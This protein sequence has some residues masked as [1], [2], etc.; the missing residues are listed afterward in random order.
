[1]LSAV[2]VFVG[3]SVLRVWK[4][5]FEVEMCVC[6]HSGQCVIK[7]FHQKWVE[8]PSSLSS[9]KSCAAKNTTAIHKKLYKDLCLCV[10]VC[11]WNALT[12]ASVHN[13][14]WDC[15]LCAPFSAML[16]CPCGLCLLC[17][18]SHYLQMMSLCISHCVL[19]QSSTH[20]SR[21]HHAE[22]LPPFLALRVVVS[23]IMW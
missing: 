8:R 20:N 22:C 1:M 23:Q 7:G 10:C 6:A 17:H 14:S 11:L 15:T 2:C 13:V 3:E 12:L 19:C 21:G 5:M 18:L 4:G 16:R 9:S